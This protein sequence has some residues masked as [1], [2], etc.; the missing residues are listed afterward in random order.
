MCAW[1]KQAFNYRIVCTCTNINEQV[2]MLTWQRPQ[3][4]IERYT[5]K[6]TTLQG[7][8]VQFTNNN[9]NYLQKLN[10]FMLLFFYY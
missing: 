8:S 4:N 9:T 6:Q 7:M 2:I 5:K 10:A 3:T 1:Q